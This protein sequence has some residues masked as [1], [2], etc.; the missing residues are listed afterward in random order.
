VTSF[1]VPASRR[2]FVVLAVLLLLGRALPV[3][4]GAAPAEQYARQCRKYARYARLESPTVPFASADECLDYGA[5]GGTVVG[6]ATR[7]NPTVKVSLQPITG[8]VTCTGTV[9]LNGFLPR[10][11][12][13]VEAV[14]RDAANPSTPVQ[15]WGPTTISTGRYGE[16]TWN[17]QTI[18]DG[19]GVYELQVRV[20][21]GAVFASAWVP[22]DC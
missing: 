7:Y 22:I 8:T 6:V 20:N 19:D 18:E 3:S 1:I 17:G 16:A 9:F 15:I 12:Y 2:L 13:T 4:A 11:T 21:G 5:G 14:W 10:S